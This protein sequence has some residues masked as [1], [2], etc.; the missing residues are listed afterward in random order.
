M[1]EYRDDGFAAAAGWEE[2]SD[3]M[4]FEEPAPETNRWLW[5][6][7]AAAT[8]ALW[9]AVAL[10]LALPRLGALDGVGA[11]QFMRKPSPY[12]WP[13]I[14]PRYNKGRSVKSSVWACNS[15]R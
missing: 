14:N 10:W 2:R 15:L 11:V 1:V 5:P 12:Q 13:P 3:D 4:T 6:A 9:F 7:L 8:V